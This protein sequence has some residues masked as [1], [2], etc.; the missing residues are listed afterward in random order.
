M[1]DNNEITRF[2]FVDNYKDIIE[3]S[4]IIRDFDKFIDMANNGLLELSKNGVLS[5]SSANLVNESIL[6]TIPVR[7]KRPMIKSFPNALSLFI[8]FSFSGLREDEIKG[9]KKYLRVNQK[10]LEQWKQFSDVEKYFS[11]FSLTFANFTFEPINERDGVLEFDTI[12]RMIAG[13]KGKLDI[14]KS[15]EYFFNM[16]QYKTI[17]ITLNMFGLIDIEDAPPL[18]SQGW[19]IKSIQ[20]KSFMGGKWHNIS[21]LRNDCF[22]SRFDDDELNDD[23]GFVVGDIDSMGRIQRFADKITEQ[24]PEFSRRLKIDLENRPGIYFFKASLGKVWRICKVDYRSSLDDLCYSILKSFNFDFD[25]LYDVKFMSSF[26]HLLTF[27]GAPEISHAEYP[28]TEDILIGDLPIKINDTMDF[29]FDYG[30]N[31]QFSIVLEKIEAVINETNEIPGIEIIGINGKAPK[32]Y[33]AW[34]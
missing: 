23:F 11:L 21:K 28:T 15:N 10:M 4:S 27:N 22:F 31:W 6:R 17:L 3:K 1:K 33:R 34:D 25:H 29:T 20:P 8:L 24:I 13:V 5:M 26:G 30:D 12:I 7:L 14:N 16:Y 2:Q 19:N 32:Q 18:E 9:K